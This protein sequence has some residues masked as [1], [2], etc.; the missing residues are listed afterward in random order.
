MKRW[1][2]S[3]RDTCHHERT[4]LIDVAADVVRPGKRKLYF[5]IIDI[6]DA[7]AHI[8]Y[9][10]ASLLHPSSFS[11]L[12]YHIISI[13]KVWFLICCLWSQHLS[14]HQHLFL[15]MNHLH[16]QGKNLQLLPLLQTRLVVHRLTNLHHFLVKSSHGILDFMGWSTSN[17]VFKLL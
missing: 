17:L 2:S 10:I 11:N 14:H 13:I 5:I 1:V 9:K 4:R 8:V 16:L 15:M 6:V 12:R 3:V 7:S